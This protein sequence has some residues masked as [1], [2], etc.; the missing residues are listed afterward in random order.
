MR[1]FLST[2]GFAVNVLRENAALLGIPVIVVTAK[3]LTPRA[4]ARLI[5]DSFE[6][7]PRGTISVKGKG[8]MKTFLLIA[9][10]SAPTETDSPAET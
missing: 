5:E 1:S 3:T 4:A 6:L 10:E 7:E 2:Q 8:K 9:A